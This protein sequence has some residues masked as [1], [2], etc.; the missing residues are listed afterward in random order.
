MKT[1]RQARRV[2][3]DLYLPDGFGTCVLGERASANVQPWV[4]LSHTLFGL[5]LH[6]FYSQ[7]GQV[8]STANKLMNSLMGK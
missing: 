4:S 8:F 5:T 6:L 1:T 2:I 3:L 7:A